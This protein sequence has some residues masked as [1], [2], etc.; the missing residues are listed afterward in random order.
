M[1]F[2]ACFLRIYQLLD[3]AKCEVFWPAGDSTF[4]EIPVAVCRVGIISEGVE[5]LG[6]P[7][8][9]SLDFHTEYFD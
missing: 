3:L 7:F 8:W 1:L 6:C 5:L 9:G 4:M 2:V